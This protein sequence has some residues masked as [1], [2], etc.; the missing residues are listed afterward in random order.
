MAGRRHRIGEPILVRMGKCLVI[1]GNG[2]LGSHLVDM[3]AAG[4]HEVT[5]FDRFST[6]T[7]NYKAV[8]VTPLVGDFLDRSHLSLAV[9]GQDFVFHFLSVTTPASAESDPT[10]DIRTNLAQTVDLFEFCADSGVRRIFFASSGGAIYGPSDNQASSETDPTSPVSPYGII[11]L[12]IENYL[13]YFK[14]TRG[15]EHTIFRISNPYGPRQGP[16][17]TQGLIPVV[18]NRIALG[19]PIAR[20]GDGTMIRDFLYVDD[21]MRMVGKALGEDVPHDVY[22]LGHGEGHSVNDILD[23]VRRVTGRD[24]TILEKPSPPTFIERSVLDVSRFNSDFGPVDYT[25]LD[26][27]IRATWN[28]LPSNL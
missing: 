15:L 24:F 13:G 1:G 8:N 18:L 10:L 22:N 19:L 4:G 3:L 26:D 7:K 14:A 25:D 2:F 20:F 27:G 6:G 5:A 28:L 11:K 12:A 16:A 23:S 9:A 21:L 17:K